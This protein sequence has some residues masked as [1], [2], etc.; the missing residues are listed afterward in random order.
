MD[1]M[2]PEDLVVREA[3][4]ELEELDRI[5]EARKRDRGMDYYVPNK[6]QYG[7][8]RC[9]ARTILYCGGNRAGKTTFGAMELSYHLT[10]K[11]PEWYPIDRRF[12]K[13][14]KAVVSGTSFAIVNRVIEPKLLAYLPRDYY[15]IKRTAQGYLSRIN[16]IDGSTVDFLTSEMDDMMYESADWDFAWMDEPQQ[17]RKWQGVQRGLVDRK[18]REVITFTPLT[19]PWMKEELVDKADGKRIALFTVNIRDNTQAMDGTPILSEEAIAEFEATLPEDVRETRIDGKFFHLRGV[20]YK[21]F[22]EQHISTWTY[23][24]PNPVICV[25]DPHDRVPHHVIWAFVDRQDDIFVDFEFE[26]HI[27]LDEL[28]KQILAIEKAR[29]YNVRKRIIDPNFGR[30][31]SKVGTNYT[32]I[33]ELSRN[34]CPFYEGQDNIELGHMIIRDYLHFDRKKPISATNKPKLFFHRER[35]PKTISSMRNLQY[36]EWMGKTAGEKDAKEVEKDKENHGADD[37]R[38][39]CITRPR[40][41]NLY[42]PARKAED[43]EFTASPY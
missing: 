17:K 22:G 29:G 14:I 31:P 42:D 34:G 5:R 23:E 37:V 32:V 43:S 16:C 33:Q 39:L 6:M 25:L 38:Y 19:E 40:F 10:R 12:K 11:Y 28:A 8:H 15:T 7:A 2:K 13:P 27:E 9:S 35:V 1:K 26:K 20:V 30:K 36:E 41:R 21:E 24:Y 3:L 18:G 4:A